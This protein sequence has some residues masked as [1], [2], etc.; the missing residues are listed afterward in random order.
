LR[1][2]LK[3]KGNVQEGKELRFETDEKPPTDAPET[4]SRLD[5]L[6]VMD[7]VAFLLDKNGKEF[8]FRRGNF[9]AEHG[10]E[11]AKEYDHAYSLVAPASMG[12]RVMLITFKKTSLASSVETKK[13][14]G[15]EAA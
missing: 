2:T 12:P 4:I 5:E 9:F 7:S 15:N 14:M 3:I 8:V 10:K 6:V 13:M 1:C 11:Q